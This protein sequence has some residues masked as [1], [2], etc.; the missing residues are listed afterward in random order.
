MIDSRPHVVHVVYG[1][2][3][4]GLENGVVNLINRMPAGL[5]HHTV[6]A[7]TSCASEFCARVAHDDVHFIE[8]NK[9]PG[10]AWRLYPALYRL[11][12]DLKPAIVHTRNLAAL[13]ALVPAC[14]AGVPVRIHG[15][16]GWDVSDPQGTRL[17]YRLIR[18]AHR[19]FVSRYVALSGHIEEYLAQAIGVP[20]DRISR[21]C[22][23]VDTDRFHPTP[24]GRELLSGSP[25]NESRYRVIGTVGRLQAIKDQALIV[26]AFALLRERLPEHAERLRLMI[27]G[28]GPLRALLE[29]EVE[30]LGIAD[31][32]WLT[33]ERSDVPETLRAM[34]VFVLPSL[35]E[36]ISNTIL[37]AMAS[38]LPVIAT[39]VGGNGE[40]V[41]PGHTGQLVPA[42]DAE[43][44]AEALAAYVRDPEQARA[45]G[46]AG[47]MRVENEFSLDGMVG[48]YVELYESG[49]SAAG[50]KRKMEPA[51]D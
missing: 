34:D 9:P 25:L 49:M 46:R 10:H 3:T 23:G 27:V 17:K 5:F 22:N 16:H 8:L 43:A 18:R 32:V 45:H 4:G 44:M 7:L 13:E 40:L 51:L 26:R 15:E 28:D 39:D 2:H 14:I 36:G 41:V 24:G 50:F 11:F 31:S 1:F 19:P 47:R 29:A 42:R 6:V 35:A 33:G 20:R 30:R 37:E 12:R 48:R 21:I 38:G